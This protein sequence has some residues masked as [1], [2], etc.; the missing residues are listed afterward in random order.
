MSLENKLDI[1]RGNSNIITKKNMDNGVDR[2][3]K[4]CCFHIDPHGAA[5]LGQFIIITGVISFSFIMLIQSKG[6]CEESSPYFSLIS[7]ILG[8]LLS[9]IIS[10]A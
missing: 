4:S 1:E 6:K 9:T 8:K 3:W 5:Y 2:V 10:S 7:F